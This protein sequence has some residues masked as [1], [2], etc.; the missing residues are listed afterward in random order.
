M[1]NL[2]LWFMVII[3]PN[4]ETHIQLYPNERACHIEGAFLQQYA[5]PGVMVFC[6][7]IPADDDELASQ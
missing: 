1:G 4:G 7:G 3:A 6:V 2:L 5:Q